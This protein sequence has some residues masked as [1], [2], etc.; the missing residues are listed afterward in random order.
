VHLRRVAIDPLQAVKPR[1]LMS[2]VQRERTV[3]DRSL[4][5]NSVQ[6][7]SHAMRTWTTQL[8]IPGVF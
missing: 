4:K 2:A 7:T 8:E 5:T 3:V 1:R 6:L